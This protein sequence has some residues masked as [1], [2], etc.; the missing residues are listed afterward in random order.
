LYVNGF[1]LETINSA[2]Y[3]AKGPY[4]VTINAIETDNLTVHFTELR[5]WDLAE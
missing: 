1:F 2:F 3:D 4:G 5:Y